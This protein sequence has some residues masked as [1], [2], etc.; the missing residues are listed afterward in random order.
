M[1]E[2]ISLHFMHIVRKILS[3]EQKKYTRG[4]RLDYGEDHDDVDANA[5][6]FFIGK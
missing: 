1:T 4:G 6:N 2:K 5:D 3:S